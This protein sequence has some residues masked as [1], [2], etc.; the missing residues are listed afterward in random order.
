[1]ARTLRLNRTFAAAHR[2]WNDDS[3]CQRIHGHNY[4]V[5][6]DIVVPDD[7]E[8]TAEGFV[9]A[10]GDVKAAIDTYDHQLLIHQED[11]VMVPLLD[12][13]IIDFVVVSRIPSTENLAR[14]LA[15]DIA[16]LVPRHARVHVKLR[17]TDSIE[18]T[19]STNGAKA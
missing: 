10:W 13:G 16:A 12:I 17:E 1:M 11:P 5:E 3:P 9:V 19:W 18:A 7:F 2:V 8:L 4:R 6:V 14:I 15:E